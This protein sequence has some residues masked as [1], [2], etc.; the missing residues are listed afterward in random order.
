MIRKVIVAAG[1]VGAAI[2]LFGVG[3]AQ[4]DPNTVGKT[5]ADAKSA[6]Q[7]AGLQGQVSTRVGDRLP[8]DQCIVTSQT[9]TAKPPA[10]FTKSASSII[11]VSLDCN[12]DVASAS[13]PGYSAASPEAQKMLKE[14][15]NREWL[16]TDDGQAWCHTAAKEH[17]DWKLNCDSY[18]S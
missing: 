12:G 5:W 3:V 1:A 16:G 14:K 8:E 17:P 9:K 4:A 18:L 6:I 2:A 7:S 11:L 13:N 10:G 15:Q